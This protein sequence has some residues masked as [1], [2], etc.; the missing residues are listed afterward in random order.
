MNPILSMTRNATATET[1]NTRAVA[2]LEAIRS[3]KWCEP[4]QCLRDSHHRAVAE[5]R[6]AG[7]AVSEQKKR[8]PG[9]L[10]SGQFE[11]RANAG[12]T[13]HSGLLC[14]DLDALG[15]LIPTVRAQLRTSPHLFALF[16]SP[17]ATGLKAVFRVPTDPERHLA[18]FH[19]V[20]SHV[21]NLCGADVDPAC[22]DVARLC[23]VS[24]DPH[25]YLNTEATELTPL[26]A[27][28]EPQRAKL[29]LPFVPNGNLP[30]SAQRLLAH[31]VGSG[32][33]NVAAFKLAC[34][35]R[36]AGLSETEA[37]SSILQFAA[38]CQ[39][40][41]ANGEG[42][43]AVRSSYK[44]APRQPARI[45]CTMPYKANSIAREYLGADQVTPAPWPER[46]PLPN[47]MPPV[48]PLPLDAL[49]ASF[50][51]WIEDCAERMQ[52][53][54][55]FIAAAALVAA[56]SVLGN[57]I[58]IAPKKFDHWLEV[59]SFWGAVVGR[60]GTMK[61]PA[62][63]AALV[64]L[65]RLE[66][67]A[68]SQHEQTLSKHSAE[69]LVADEVRKK[70]KGELAK[71]FKAN[72]QEAHRF[73]AKLLSAETPP[74]PCRRYFS[75]DPTVPKLG[76]LLQD[77]PTGMLLLRDELTGFFRTFEADG[78]EGDRAFF[79]EGWNGKQPY[80]VDRIERGTIRIDRHCVSILG[81]IQPGPLQTI[82]R[83]AVKC[84]SGDDGLL[85]RFQIVVWPDKSDWRNVDRLPDNSA[86]ALY[87][88]AFERLDRLDP[89][90]VGAMELTKG[91]IPALHF[92]HEAQLRFDEWRAAHE[93]GI[94]AGDEH[95]AFEAYLA[96][97]PRTVATLALLH[98]LADGGT[99]PVRLRS[100][101]AALALQKALATHARRLYAP[102]LQGPVFAARE[103]V[104]HL[105]RGD[106]EAGFTSR[107]VH[108]KGWTNLDTPELA[109]EACLYLL[110]LNWLREV[111]GAA[112]GRPTERFE[113]HPDILKKA[114]PGTAKSDETVLSSVSSAS[115]TP[116]LEHPEASQDAWPDG[117]AVL[118]SPGGFASED[119]F[120][121][122]VPTENE[123]VIL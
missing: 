1:A 114:P 101:D 119:A 8:L 42:L 109:R 66:A 111:P 45:G 26:V 33:R 118:E 74:P 6:N 123:G 51:P 122:S 113:A 107:D 12:L 46:K 14:A 91:D 121:P 103:L 97:V 93:L 116:P 96:K 30:P 98:H 89:S 63:S 59:P 38:R 64:P 50:R 108:R 23:F 10:W 13:S 40:P 117:S 112:T 90:A 69:Q 19:A 52:C 92:D 77:N 24:H 70:S 62:L 73:A 15:D 41:L 28:A 56:G 18:S 57:R 81:G 25:A 4:I 32:E 84:G 80:T 27:P 43:A 54:P 99:G 7:E 47:S 39:P 22:K 110:D 31:G 104:R 67:I 88:A 68:S 9:V 61:S 48:I 87:F 94:R 36:D 100:L 55:D 65:H 78:R 79:L 76:E 60:P 2:T 86:R 34:Q 106:L 85:Q 115:P 83:S 16:L 17:T 95:P 105:E 82:V 75:N 53:A 5:G 29:K 58:A 44:A 71:M 49:P 37:E 21:R 72:P 11:R 102:A 20:S 35:L 120:A 3:G